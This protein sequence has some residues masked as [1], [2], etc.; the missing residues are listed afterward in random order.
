[1]EPTNS[2]NAEKTQRWLRC[3]RPR[4]EA[5]LRLFCFPYA[6]RGAS[7]FRTWGDHLPDGIEV[8]AVQPP[9]REDR[10]RDR[11]FRRLS[12]LVEAAAGAI[13][14]WC[15]R[16]FAYF[17]HSMGALTAFELARLRRRNGQSMPEWLFVSGRRAPHLRDPERPIPDLPD[18]EFARELQRR[19]QGIPAVIAEDPKLR[20]F[21]LP[22]VKA[23]LE[24]VNTY[25]CEPHPPLDVPIS[26]FGGTDDAIGPEELHAWQLHTTGRCRVRMLPG[27]HFFINTRAEG[28]L[29]K[30]VEDLRGVVG[31]V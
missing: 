30:V 31:N 17:G 15:D 10:F 6:G 20:A 29:R 19:Y 9:G 23:D 14:S 1:M 26:V 12:P 11:P 4:P 22:M 21:F 25:G 2:T 18:E 8:V 7:L 5:R 24:V 28:I 16:P 13:E 3:F 27:D